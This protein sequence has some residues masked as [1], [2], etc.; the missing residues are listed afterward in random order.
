MGILRKLGFQDIGVQT[1]AKC[2]KLSSLWEVQEDGITY[3]CQECSDEVAEGKRLRKELAI[4]T[5][6][7]CGTNRNLTANP[8]CPR[9]GASAIQEVKK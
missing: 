3:I 2:G 6:A 4:V 9:C 7:H 5:C 8:E 1:C